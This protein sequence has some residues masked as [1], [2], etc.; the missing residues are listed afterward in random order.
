MLYYKVKPSSDQVRTN[1]KKGFLIANELITEN[2][3]KRKYFSGVNIAAHCE[4]V[5]VKPK[6]T[7]F[8]FG[9]RFQVGQ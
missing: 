3:S 9:A 8:F 2:E 5:N 1:G 4:Q 7:Y 6:E